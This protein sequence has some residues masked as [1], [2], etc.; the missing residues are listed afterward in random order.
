[1]PPGVPF[2]WPLCGRS[3]RWSSGFLDRI[4]SSWLY[5][6]CESRF[7]FAGPPLR[8][9]QCY[10][11]GFPSMISWAFKPCPPSQTSLS[12]WGHPAPCPFR[13]Y[14]SPSCSGCPFLYFHSPPTSGSPLP[15]WW[16]LEPSFFP[17]AALRVVWLAGSARRPPGPPGSG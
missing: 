5:W 3:N 16:P 17:P 11:T 1:M 10:P 8:R 12:A 9:C 7:H 4:A 13:H 14:R 6:L 15:P 2:R